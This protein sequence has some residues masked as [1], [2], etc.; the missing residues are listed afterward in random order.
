MLQFELGV[1]RQNGR[2]DA[3]FDFAGWLPAGIGTGISFDEEL[4]LS[5]AVIAVTT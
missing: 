1:P 5:S 2:D 3:E 4:R